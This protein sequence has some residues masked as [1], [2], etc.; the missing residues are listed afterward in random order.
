MNNLNIRKATLKDK[1]TL[2]ALE[3]KVVEAERPFNNAIKPDGA[4][5]YDLDDLLQGT[6][7]LVLVV[8]ANNEIVGTG[9]AQ[10]RRSKKSL[11]HEKHAYLGF[12]YVAPEYRGKGL[13]KRLLENLIDWS[14]GNNVFDFY[15]D[16]Y[17][18]N[19]A[20]I[21]AYEKVGF[22]SS[23]IEMKMHLKD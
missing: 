8:E 13:N 20:A 9:Y 21:R 5:Y 16:V 3:Q 1:S 4:I 23:M 18:Q 19:D 7:S 17:A 22:D 12:M 10:I 11:I 2:L 6:E 15:L 14:K